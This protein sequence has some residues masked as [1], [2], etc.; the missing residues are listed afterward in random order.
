MA[1]WRKKSP[2][3]LKDGTAENHSKIVDSTCQKTGEQHVDVKE[4]KSVN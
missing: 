2:Q 1:E 3:I 4:L